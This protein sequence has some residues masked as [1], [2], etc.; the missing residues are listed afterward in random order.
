MAEVLIGAPAQTIVFN[1]DQNGWSSFMSYIPDFYARLNNRLFT[2]FNGQLYLHNDNDNS[3]RNNFYGTQYGSQIRTVIN[4]EPAKDK[5]FKTIVLESDEA[6]SVKLST[7]YTDGTIIAS[8]FEQKESRFFAFT[9]KNESTTN[10]VGAI[11]GIGTISAVVGTNITFNQIPDI[12]SIGDTLYQLNVSAQETIG[13]ITNINRTTN[14][15]TVTTIITTPVVGF[16][17]FSR[18]IARY[19]SENLRGY[20]LDVTLTNNSTLESELFAVNSNA[21]PSYI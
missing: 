20:Y 1:E 7:N 10:N 16:Y 17:S 11:Q 21:I 2:V 3:I 5:V 19:E 14:V 13:V 18:K 15:I 6:W 9:R 12:I 4:D 8:E